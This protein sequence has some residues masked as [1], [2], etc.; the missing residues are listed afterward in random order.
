MFKDGEP[1]LVENYSGISLLSVLDK[2]QE[3]ILYSA[4]YDQIS[5]YLYDSYHGF[6]KGRST[7]TQLLLVHNDLA[8]ALDNRGQISVIF[9]YFS[10]VFDLADHAKLHLTNRQQRTVVRGISS[11]WLSVT[12]G[13]PQGYFGTL[14]LHYRVAY[15]RRPISGG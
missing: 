14:V 3:R 6:L 4:I 9:L 12:S 10:Q 5:Q 2:R 1:S 8:E 11:D 7:V 13:V 15:E